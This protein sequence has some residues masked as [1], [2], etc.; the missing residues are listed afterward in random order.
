MCPP[1][2]ISSNRCVA[3]VSSVPNKDV[4]GLVYTRCISRIIMIS[5]A[6]NR[7]SYASG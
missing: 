6:N 3:F 4:F 1:V 7:A 2:F 5:F